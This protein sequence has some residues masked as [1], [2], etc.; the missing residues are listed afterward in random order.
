MYILAS[1]SMGQAFNRFGYFRNLSSQMSTQAL[2]LREA[3]AQL[4]EQKERLNTLRNEA[5][6]M[7]TKVLAERTQL[8][9]EEGDASRVVE[10]LQKDRKTFESS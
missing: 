4:E 9:A 5:D 1:R 6:E 2:K 7:R 8:R 3:A 10:Q